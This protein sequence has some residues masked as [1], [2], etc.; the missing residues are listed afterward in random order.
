MTQLQSAGN[1]FFPI[2]CGLLLPI[3]GALNHSI[4]LVID[5][6]LWTTSLVYGLAALI[7]LLYILRSSNVPPWKKG[8]SDL[9][10]FIRSRWYLRS[11]VLTGGAIGAAQHAVLTIIT[12][13]LGSSMYVYWV[14]MGSSPTSEQADITGLRYRLYRNSCA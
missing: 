7:T 1:Y 13:T 10:T 14:C 5:S 3:S 2:S 4:T 12:G 9:W 11:F 6:P 8:L